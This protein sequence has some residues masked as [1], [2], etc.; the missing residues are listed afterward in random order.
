MLGH[1][2]K[3]FGEGILLLLKYIIQYLN[4]LFGFCLQRRAHTSL[5]AVWNIEMKCK[6]VPLN[7]RFSS[8]S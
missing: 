3:A 7:K 2:M 5:Q 6:N 1:V 4:I 8:E